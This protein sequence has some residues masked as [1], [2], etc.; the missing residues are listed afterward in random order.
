MPAESNTISIE[1]VPHAKFGQDDTAIAATT[2]IPRFSAVRE[3]VE[4]TNGMTVL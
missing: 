3:R 4:R 2:N 1:L